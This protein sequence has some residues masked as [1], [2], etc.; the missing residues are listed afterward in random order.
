MILK[1]KAV[2][3]SDKAVVM[4]NITKTYDGKRKVLDSLCWEINSGEFI[5]ILGQSGIGKSTLLNIL[6]LLD[7]KNEGTYFL[8]GNK[9]NKTTNRHCALLR[10]RYIGFVFQH[11]YLLPHLTVEKNLATPFLYS[12][13]CINPKEIE[14]RI[15]TLLV[16]MGLIQFRN[17]KVD[18]LSGGEKQRVA[19]ARAL[20]VKPKLLIADEPTGNLDEP[21]AQRIMSIIEEYN[22]EGN[23]IVMVTHNKE[24]AKY[25]NKQYT[26]SGGKLE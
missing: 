9:I 17:S 11:Y 15:D 16:K 10:N 7:D 18:L 5:A 4:R 20:V 22:R 14:K 3:H 2:E 12:W 13:P 24:M 6:G 21:N 26:I 25:S 1:Q 19:I 8:F 23:T